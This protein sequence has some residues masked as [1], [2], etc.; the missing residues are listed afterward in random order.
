[1]VRWPRVSRLT[2]GQV[3]KVSRLTLGSHAPTVGMKQSPEVGLTLVQGD[4]II[5]FGAFIMEAHLYWNLW[6]KLAEKLLNVWPCILLA[7]M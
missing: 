3:L 4:N 2:F 1:M 5:F 6:G 7:L